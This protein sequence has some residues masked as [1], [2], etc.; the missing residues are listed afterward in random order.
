MELRYN[1]LAGLV[2]AATESGRQISELVLADQAKQMERD[3]KLLFQE[4][5]R[6][7]TVMDE[8]ADE[9]V[10]PDLRSTSALTA[11]IRSVAAFLRAR[12]R[13]RSPFQS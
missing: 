10:Q 11:V 2:R 5:D 4:M 6:R 8:A 9:G 3:P 12:W 7:L 13:A 1:S